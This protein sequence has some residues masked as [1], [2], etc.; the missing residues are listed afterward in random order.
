[1]AYLV[2]RDEQQRLLSRYRIVTE[3]VTI[4]RSGDST[5]KLTDASVSENHAVITLSTSCLQVR[6]LGST[7]G[8]YVG[9]HRVE[10]RVTVQ[11][12]DTLSIGTYHIEL[13]APETDTDLIA[14]HETGVISLNDKLLR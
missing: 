10:G 6:D 2:V 7:N 12:G 4:G 5:V 9:G 11:L 1:L 14:V 8:T 3:Q 13:L